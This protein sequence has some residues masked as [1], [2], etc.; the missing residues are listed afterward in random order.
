MIKWL[1]EKKGDKSAADHRWHNVCQSGNW[2]R[3]AQK[4]QSDDNCQLQKSVDLANKKKKKS[5]LS[6]MKG[7]GRISQ[8][9]PSLLTLPIIATSFFSGHKQ[10]DSIAVG[11]NWGLEE[12]PLQWHWSPLTAHHCQSMIISEWRSWW[13]HVASPSSSFSFSIRSSSS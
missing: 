11:T 7:G 13:A 8:R 10:M 1:P 3:Q 4:W 6:W 5:Y 9:Q 12:C 2:E